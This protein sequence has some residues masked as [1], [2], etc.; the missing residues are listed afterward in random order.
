MSIIKYL[1]PSFFFHKPCENLF[2]LK[3]YYFSDLFCIFVP[4][5][6]KDMVNEQKIYMHSAEMAG[7]AKMH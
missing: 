3:N 4:I 1:E 2:F 7:H 6:E 5:K